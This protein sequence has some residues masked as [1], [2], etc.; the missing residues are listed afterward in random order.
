MSASRAS[1]ALDTSG[2]GK[3]ADP[4][5]NVPAWK[6]ASD[7]PQAQTRHAV[8]RSVW[9]AVNILLLFS[10]L[11]VVWSSAWEYST[12]RYLKGFSD[13]I[14][15]FSATPI[16]KVQSILGWMSHTPARFGQAPASLSDDRDPM[17]TLNYD[18]LLRVCGTATNA[19]INLADSSG[20]TARRLLL[21]DANRGA[22][23][24]V[25]EVLVNGRW[26]VV[27]PTFHAIFR[28]P[29]GDTLTNEDLANPGVFAAA[30]RNIPGYDPSY[31][32]DNTVH[33]RMARFGAFGLA[34]RRVLDA[35]LPNWEG[36][37]TLSIIVERESLGMTVLF[38]IGALLL[39]LIRTSLRW[40]GE[41]RLGVHPDRMRNRL[42]RLGH[43]LL[44]PAD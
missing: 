14:V 39:L 43:L 12:R 30:T 23:H 24:V 33:V 3:G 5:A 21:L 29:T 40:Y 4:A 11:G 27:D 22:M 13:A 44:N 25:A 16:Q 17:D 32:F 42:R 2:P 18:S 6:L 36:S 26:I 10:L 41:A 15:P 28:G 34:G 35:A 19:F 20:L 1:R 7:S 9:I 37:S 31:V 8:F 38:T